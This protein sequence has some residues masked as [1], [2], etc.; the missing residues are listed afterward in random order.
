MKALL[1][2]LRLAKKQAQGLRYSIEDS[3]AEAKG[4]EEDENKKKELWNDST[5]LISDDI[6]LPGV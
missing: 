6:W 5:I 4:A 3:I 1:E 2:E